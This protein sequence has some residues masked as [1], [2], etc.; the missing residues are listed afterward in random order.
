MGSVCMVPPGG[1]GRGW[2]GLGGQA[3]VGTGRQAWSCRFL[4][5]IHTVSA[6]DSQPVSCTQ[7]PREI[8]PRP[9]LLPR[10]WPSLCS[11]AVW[12]DRPLH[13]LSLR[14]LICKMGKTAALTCTLGGV[15]LL[16]SWRKSPPG[17]AC[18]LVEQK[19]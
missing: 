5:A 11:A 7:M 3:A 18:A 16:G 17:R 10:W 15:P 4:A 2:A 1:A 19:G 9:Q 13:P 6:L 8:G 14:S 12:L